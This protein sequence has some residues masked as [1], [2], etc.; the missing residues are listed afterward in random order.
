M[1]ESKRIH[2][3]PDQIRKVKE[4][5]A[6]I[7]RKSKLPPDLPISDIS[8]GDLLD[9]SRL[10][11]HREI[12]NLTY[13]SSQGK[14]SKDS[15]QSLR[16]YVKLLTDLNERE[17]ELVKDLSADQLKEITNESQQTSSK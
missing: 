8:F 17:K 1:S 3:H 10:I 7:A 14:L 11:L 13:E 6:E 5:E 9:R 15:A 16:D 4:E 12:G 2:I